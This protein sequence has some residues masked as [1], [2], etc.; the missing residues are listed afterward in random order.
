MIPLLR[1]VEVRT[2]SIGSPAAAES[3]SRGVTIRAENRMPSGKAVGGAW[4]VGGDWSSPPGR[5]STLYRIVNV[6]PYSWHPAYEVEL[7]VSPPSRRRTRRFVSRG[8]SSARPW[9]GVL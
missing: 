6:L 8:T 3:G 5:S 4:P 2:A 1:M 7:D 9:I